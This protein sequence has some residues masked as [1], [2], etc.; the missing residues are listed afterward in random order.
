MKDPSNVRCSTSI[1][2]ITRALV[3]ANRVGKVRRRAG[4]SRWRALEHKEFRALVAAPKH[5]DRSKGGS[6]SC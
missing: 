4:L 1:Q 5:Q 3:P 2:G 6:R